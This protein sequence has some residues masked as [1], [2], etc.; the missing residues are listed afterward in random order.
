MARAASRRW[1]PQEEVP[2]DRCG[3][4]EEK[5]KKN[6]HMFIE[7]ERECGISYIHCGTWK[8]VIQGIHN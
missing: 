3:C 7:C 1:V 4:W 6:M 2:A 8:R 5:T